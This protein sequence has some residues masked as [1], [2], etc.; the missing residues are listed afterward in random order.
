[1][2]TL[3]LKQF[4]EHEKVELFVAHIFH[5]FLNDNNYDITE[6]HARKYAKFIL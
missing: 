6:I 1:M 2:S 4:L 5:F 3:K